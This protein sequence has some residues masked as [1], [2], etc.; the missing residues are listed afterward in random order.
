MT[1]K[2]I[3]RGGVMTEPKRILLLAGT[4]E[5]VKINH[6]LNGS[7]DI[8]LTTSLAGRTTDPAHLQGRVITGG[9]GGAEGLSDFLAEKEIT[10]LVD[11]T[12]PFAAHMTRTAIEMSQRQKV[13]FFR[14]Q[15]PA[16]EQQP[17]DHW[18]HA[19]NVAAA[20]SMLVGY[21]RIFLS[22]GRQELGAFGGATDKFFLVRSIEAVDFEPQGSSVEYIRARGP[23]LLEDEIRILTDHKIDLLVSKNSGGDATGAKIAAAQ[24]LQIPVLMIDRPAAPDC[25]IF[26][27]IDALVAAVLGLR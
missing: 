8:E 3:L 22:I 9:F 10:H 19:E 27:T 7:K 18:I 16:W 13:E 4:E 17:R 2:V 23:F 11:A 25:A 1:V 20:A 14:Y 26:E 6:A 5:A 21:R 24:E 12:H 15:R